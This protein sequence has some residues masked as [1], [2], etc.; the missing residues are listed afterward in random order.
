MVNNNQRKLFIWLFLVSVIGVGLAVVSHLHFVEFKYGLKSTPSF[1]N[2][3]E[4]FNCDAVTQSD[5]ASLAGIPLAA[6]GA[7]FYLLSFVFALVFTFSKSI[8]PK[9]FKSAILLSGVCA[10]I[11]SIIL[12]YISEFIIGTICTI[13]MGMYLVN[14]AILFLSLRLN[15]GCSFWK[16]L[17]EGF[18]TLVSWPLVVCGYYRSTEKSFVKNSRRAFWLTVLITFYSLFLQEPLIYGLATG[19][20]LKKQEKRTLSAVD[21]ELKKWRSAPVEDLKLQDGSVLER[22]F[23]KGPAEAPIQIVEFSD[24]ECPFCNMVHFVLKELA[25]QY[26]GKVS[27][28]FKNYPLDHQCNPGIKSPYHLNACFA[29]HITRCAGEQGQF[30]EAADNF[31]NLK[32]EMQRA[33]ASE[34]RTKVL[35]QLADDGFDVEALE[36]CV[37]SLRHGEKILSDIRQADAL[38]IVGTP[39]VWVNNKRV[40]KFSKELLEAIFDEILN[41][42]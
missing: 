12:F 31:F 10:V 35:E 22:D 3:N 28:T 11:Y 42:E 24:F 15:R 29:A 34:L 17:K 33:E 26:P 39:T 9:P 16:A 41:Q 36:S 4:A 6:F 14:F 20:L 40:N 13:C 7:A 8:D 38:N 30:W 27:I 19:S 5:W 32:S 23:R 21:G 18:I 25:D 37:K 2:I 1:C